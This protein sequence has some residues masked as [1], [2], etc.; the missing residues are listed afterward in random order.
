MMWTVCPLREIVMRSQFSLV[1]SSRARLVRFSSPQMLPENG[2]GAHC[3]QRGDERG[4]P[5]EIDGEIATA[6]KDPR[7]EYRPRGLEPVHGAF[8]DQLPL[9]LGRED[10]EHEAAGRL[11]LSICVRQVLHGVDQVG[12]VGACLAGNSRPA[13]ERTARVLAGL[14]ADRFGAADLAAGRWST[15]ADRHQHAVVGRVPT[16]SPWAT[17]TPASSR[18]SW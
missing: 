16:R 11:V 14:A 7:R 6:L 12:E 8:P 10:A 18:P 15:A 17:A 9:E 1:R 4:A 13:G 5:E 3:G 2:L